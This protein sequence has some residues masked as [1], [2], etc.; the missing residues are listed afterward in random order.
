M[1]KGPT[2]ADSETPLAAKAYEDGKVDGKKHEVDNREGCS[3][4]YN[5]QLS[6]MS[7]LAAKGDKTKLTG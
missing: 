2:A 6:A 5:C 7:V 3:L 1:S 4:F